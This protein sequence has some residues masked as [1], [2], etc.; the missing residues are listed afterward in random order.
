LSNGDGSIWKLILRQAQYTG[1]GGMLYFLFSW[2]SL[3]T[4]QFGISN[5]TFRPAAAILV[6][7]GILYGPIAGFFAGVFGK[8]LI[9]FVAGWGFYWN[10]ILSYGLI[11]LIPGF[12]QIA[13]KDF[14]S[15]QHILRAVLWGGFGVL[16]SALFFFVTE[17]FFGGIKYEVAFRN[18]FLP[19]FIGNLVIVI[20]FLPLFMI[21]LA[22]MIRK[23]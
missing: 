1:I 21:V 15:T 3:N 13:F 12:L 11:G 16:C 20:I 2:L 6:L 23:N 18:F 22:V 19:E 4:F 9:D 17:A 14:R 10:G 7:V 5:I 8:A